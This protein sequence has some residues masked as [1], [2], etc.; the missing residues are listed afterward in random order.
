MRPT[1]KTLLN[2]TSRKKRDTMM[3]WVNTNMANGNSDNMH[4]GKAV[5]N[6]TTGGFFVWS[7]TARDFTTNT[8]TTPGVLI[9]EATRTAT[10]CFMRGLSERIDI[11]TTSA[12]PWRWRR[13]CFTA[14]DPTL[15]AFNQSGAVTPYNGWWETSQGV[16]R[17]WVNNFI[18]ATPTQNAVFVE[19]LFMG[20]FN[21][22]WTDYYTAKVDT[23]RIDVKY[24]RTVVIQSGNQSGVMRKHHMWHSM[25]KNIVY[26]DEQ[27]GA[28]MTGSAYSVQDKRGM[29]DYIIV[30]F[31]APHDAASATD[32]I[33][34]QSNSTVYW[35]EK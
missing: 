22:D 31:I 8:G 35:H 28:G 24:D 32:L 17:S 29:G 15:L 3:Q 4:T 10:T 14:K 13:I 26:D 2:I 23:R 12:I 21:N 6:G 27:R 30:D 34:F 11:Q 18:N 5:V 19:V 33:S 25:N 1:K 9:D 7:P 20:T 16:G